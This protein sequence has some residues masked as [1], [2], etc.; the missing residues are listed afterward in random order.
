MNSPTKPEPWLIITMQRC[1]GTSLSQFLDACSPFDTAQ[2]EPFLR[3]R[4]YGFATQRHREN[5]DIAR[6]TGDLYSVLKKRENIKHCLCTAHPDIT[7]IL[8]DLA[9]DMN[10]PVILL[11]RHDE[12]ARFRSLMIAKSTKLWFRNRPK[13]FNTRLQKLKSGEATAKPI[14]LEKAASRMGHFLDLK[15]QTLAHID[16]IKLSPLHIFYEDFYQP[17]TLAQNAIDLAKQ[18]GMDCAPDAPHLAR[19]LSIDPNKHRAQIEQ[20]PPN[21]PAFDEMLKKLQP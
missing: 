2:D 9:H 16:Q 19:L 11:L 12:I 21:L 5:P 4:Q 20:L 6:L 18:L 14:N 1:G 8:L 17:Q 7:N 15:N 13:I 3:A 10:R